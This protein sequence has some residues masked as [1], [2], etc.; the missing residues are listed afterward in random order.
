VVDVFDDSHDRLMRRRVF[1]SSEAAT[2]LALADWPGLR[3]IL[4][5][6]SIRGMPVWAQILGELAATYSHSCLADY[7]ISC[8]S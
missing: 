8:D 2:L 6:E 1:V 3:T 5:V 4:A 7:V